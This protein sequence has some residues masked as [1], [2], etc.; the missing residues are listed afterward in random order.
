MAAVFKTQDPRLVFRAAFHALFDQPPDRFR[1]AG[2]V[3]L[4]LAPLVEQFEIVGH[5]SH[6][7]ERACARLR[8]PRA[9]FDFVRF[10]GWLFCHGDMIT[11]AASRARRAG[12]WFVDY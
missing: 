6:A 2:P 1:P 12:L 5:E 8:R 10:V 3:G 9:P 4:R 7:D 11:A